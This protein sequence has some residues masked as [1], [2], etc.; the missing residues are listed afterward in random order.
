[1]RAGFLMPATSSTPDDTSMPNGRT[2]VT[3]SRHVLRPQPA[4]QQRA[5]GGGKPR[6]ALPVRPGAGSS[7]IHRIVGVDEQHHA[8]RPPRRAVPSSTR[9]IAFTTGRVSAFE[10]LRRLVA[11]QLHGAETDGVRDGVDVFRRLVHEHTDRRHER[12]QRPHDRT[13]PLRVDVTAAP[14]PRK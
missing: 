13:R 14:G 5:P 11:V 9:P 3:A 7:A 10:H 6:R 12:R 2:A 4:G 8:C 1:M